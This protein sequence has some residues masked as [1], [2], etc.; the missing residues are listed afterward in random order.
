MTVGVD[1]HHRI[2]GPEGAPQV[3]LLHA[4]GTSTRMWAPQQTALSID[5][6]VISIDLRGH[7]QSPAPPGPYAMGEL[8]GDVIGVL[9]RLG[10]ERASICGLSLGA[11]V[12]TTIASIAPDRVDRLVAA[13]IVA[14][15][16]SPAAWHER[17]Q[18]VLAGGSEAISD[19][20]IER[21]GYRDR[22]PE[23]ARLVRDMLAA[24]APAGYAG[25]CEAIAGMNLRPGFPLVTAPTLLLAG[26]E[27][28]AAP[29]SVAREMATAMPDAR[30]TV[31]DGAAHL[32]NVEAAAATTEAILEHL[33]R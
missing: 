15:P 23:I 11:M 4:L 32:L 30:V 6:R 5:H 10:I 21:W 17:A 31:I 29:V 26:S 9:D 33:G 20:V 7:G 12:G 3:V 13:S 25:C 22:A 28:P 16:A 2:D 19:L 24:T 14:V 18:R 1:L 8:A 27:D